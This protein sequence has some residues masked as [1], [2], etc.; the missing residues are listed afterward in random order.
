MYIELKIEID[1]S[2][3]TKNITKKKKKKQKD[4][5]NPSVIRS[6]IEIILEKRKFEQ[7]WEV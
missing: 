1:M 5:N 6:K 4:I 7:E 2:K 3:E